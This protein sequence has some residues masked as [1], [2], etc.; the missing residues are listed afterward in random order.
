MIALLQPA[1]LFVLMGV[2]GSGKSTVGAA[3]APRLGGVFLDGDA[4]H[5][6]ENVAKM[7]R[8][9]PLTDAD[10]RPWLQRVGRKMAERQGI[11]IAGCSA[12]K[13]AYRDLIRQ[14]AREPVAFVL[15]DGSRSLLEERMARRRGH[16]MPASLLASQLATLEPPGGDE[17]AAV[18]DIAGSTEEIV[19]RILAR[20]KGNKA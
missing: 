16:F 2:S 6:A 12:L 3:L 8:G 10:R 7:S 5:T 14:A 15:L 18:V 4:F 17:N 19:E 13:R 1:R 11:V 9:E 20:L